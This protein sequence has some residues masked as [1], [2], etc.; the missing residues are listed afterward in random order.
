MVLKLKKNFYVEALNLINEKKQI[1]E[2]IKTLGWAKSEA[3]KHHP[4]LF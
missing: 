3:Q 4:T 1:L 2:E